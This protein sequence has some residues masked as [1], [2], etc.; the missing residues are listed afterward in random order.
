MS[1]VTEILDRLTGIAVVKAQLDITAEEVRKM[2]DW[3]LD[4]E[5]RVIRLESGVPLGAP[6]TARRPRLTGKPAK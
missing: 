2:G 4:I 5:K 1:L 3:L 6:A